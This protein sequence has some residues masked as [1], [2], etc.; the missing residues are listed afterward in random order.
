MPLYSTITTTK[1]SPKVVF[2]TLLAD[3]SVKT[4]TPSPRLSSI[5]EAIQHNCPTYNRS[6]DTLKNG[7]N[8]SL[9]S[10][11]RRL[12]PSNAIISGL[13]PEK[14]LRRWSSSILHRS[15]S[16]SS[17]VDRK[18]SPSIPVS[19]SPSYSISTVNVAAK[20]NTENL[21]K[22][23]VVSTATPEIDGQVALALTSV[24]SSEVPK[25]PSRTKHLLYN[26][27][28][29]CETGQKITYNAVT[30]ELGYQDYRQ[31]GQINHVL[32]IHPAFRNSGS[33]INT[34]STSCDSG[35]SISDVIEQWSLTFPKPPN[36]TIDEKYIKLFQ[37]Q[38]KP[39]RSTQ[40]ELEDKKPSV[41]Q[42]VTRTKNDY[43]ETTGESKVSSMTCINV[44]K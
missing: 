12:L 40:L 38:D 28:K 11:T 8:N 9:T 3:Q 26:A 23:V 17:F 14:V 20:T 41:Q 7:K 25:P 21:N 19:P 5:V 18:L 22:E 6:P 16:E 36:S 44:C 4:L 34:S 29:S 27:D 2:E 30:G 32:S 33:S 35:L 42:D 13:S 10:L 43:P 15:N 24:S 1:T 37:S 31:S 39:D